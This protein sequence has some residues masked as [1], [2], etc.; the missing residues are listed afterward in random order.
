M[1]DVRRQ[2]IIEA[3]TNLDSLKEDGIWYSGL[4]GEAST[5]NRL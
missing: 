2:Q 1:K 4:E 5:K 3:F